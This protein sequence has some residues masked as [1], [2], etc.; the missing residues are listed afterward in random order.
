MKRELIVA[1]LA[2][3]V[4][5]TEALAQETLRVAVPQRG[6]W[7]TSITELG[8][9]AGIFKNHGLTLEIL[10][11][12]GGAE[13]I[14]AV[15]AGSMDIATAA[16]VASAL[17]AYAK[18]APLRIIGSEMIGSPDLYWYVVPNSPIRTIAD[19]N[20]KTIGYSVAGS[21]S[22][23]ALLEL[24]AQHNIKAKPVS[25]GGMQGTL[26]QTMSGQI[27]VGWAAAPFALDMLEQGK[28][29]I[30][31][32]GSEIAALKGRTVRVNLA[33][34]QTLERRK[35]E[36]ARFMQATRDATEWL[37]T[38][39]AALKM[40]GEFANLPDSVVRRVRDFIPMETMSP[41]RIVGM[42]QIIADAVKFKFI[43]AALT[44]EQVKQLVQIPPPRK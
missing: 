15:I 44:A 9:R 20:D 4:L 2:W 22:H 29:R 23:A 21:S 28:I 11:T 17:G 40:Y 33:N 42:E 1:L 31:A 8:Q 5:A 14:Q 12:Q 6:A 32:R 19:L 24:L 3:A 35:D 43:P 34:V 7:D 41:D 13:S 26:T 25:T 36:V 38:D 18:G 39:P 16:G 10:Y 27:D 30:V 37:Y